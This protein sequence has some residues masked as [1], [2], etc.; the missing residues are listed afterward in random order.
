VK[1]ITV[2]E[3]REFRDGNK[4]GLRQYAVDIK[5][6]MANLSQIRFDMPNE[7]TTLLNDVKTGTPVFFLPPIEGIFEG[8]KALAK[9]IP[10]PVV[11]I[12][13]LKS[14]N[15]LKDFKKV[16]HYFKDKLQQIA[17]DGNYDIVGHS[18]GALIGVHLLRSNHLPIK[19]LILLDPIESSLDDS[20]S[21]DTDERFEIVLSY[22]KSYMPNRIIGQ[23][24][25]DVLEVKGEQARINKLIELMKHYTGKHR[26]GKDY[27]EIIRG[28]FQRADMMIK[29]QKKHT[30]EYITKKIVK[31][32]LKNVKTDFTLI[33]LLKKEEDVNSIEPKLLKSFGFKKEYIEG[34]FDIHTII[35][36]EAEYLTTHLQKV[37]NILREKL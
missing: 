33:K 30:F 15:E 9:E 34:K 3:L 36:S 10:R 21:W 23:V 27:E 28:S 19:S 24:Y 8:L 12:N 17:P 37:A 20:T 13:W 1:K 2:G 16:C 5:K 32:K 26:T 11:A 35:G 14:M 7:Q 25:K 18:F 22:L 6:T 29:Y 31:R 4:D